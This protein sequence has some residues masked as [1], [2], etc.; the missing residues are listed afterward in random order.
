[1]PYTDTSLDNLIINILTNQ[2]YNSI[3]SPSDSELYLITD[4]IPVSAGT[5]LSST[6]LNNTTI[7][8]HSNSTTL[9]STQGLYPI[10]IDET[11]HISSSGSVIVIG[12]DTSTFLRNDGT[13]QPANNTI[14][15]I[16]VWE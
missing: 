8:N 6:I 10:T 3:S 13:W 14:T 2:E 5:G 11:G 4:D 7:I 12:S 16:R 15:T 9:K 1:M